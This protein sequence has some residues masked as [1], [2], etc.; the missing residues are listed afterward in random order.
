MVHV[1]TGPSARL[2]SRA[3]SVLQGLVA[4]NA[5]GGGAFGLAGAP[6]L[7]P[8]WLAGSPFSSYLIPSL[9]LIVAV[10][11]VHLV[12]AVRVWQRHPHARPLSVG[13]GAIL[14]GWIAV[15]VAI[16]GYVSWLQPAMGVVALIELA[17]AV[18]LLGKRR[19]PASR[20]GDRQ[21]V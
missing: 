16:I 11:G 18:M 12:A 5:F 8:E 10:G 6:G 1:A 20:T 17:F 7:P 2:P 13:A 14:G 21:A 3:L 19:L 4:L 15:Q 9:V